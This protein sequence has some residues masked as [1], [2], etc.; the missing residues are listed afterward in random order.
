MPDQAPTVGIERKL[1]ATIFTNISGF[2]RHLKWSAA[3]MSIVV[4]RGTRLVVTRG[5]P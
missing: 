2:N 3:Y 5:R 1:A 4:Y